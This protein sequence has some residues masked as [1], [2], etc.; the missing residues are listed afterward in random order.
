[1]KLD[2][3]YRF[4]TT[5]FGMIYLIPRYNENFY[6]FGFDYEYIK[7][8]R[9]YSGTSFGI[10]QELIG[11]VPIYHMEYLKKLSFQLIKTIKNLNHSEKRFF[12]IKIKILSFFGIIE[13]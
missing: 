9:K 7:T 11:I 6:E 10:N 12:I 5:I 2:N 13:N 4:S 1:M 3:R 8:N